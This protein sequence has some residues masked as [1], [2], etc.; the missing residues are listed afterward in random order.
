RNRSAHD[1]V[2]EHEAFTLLRRLDVDHHV[3]V[4][5]FTARLANEFPFDFLDALLDRLA[6][7]NLRTPDIRIDLE[8]ALHAVDDDLEVQFAHSGDDRLTGLLIGMNAERRI[9]FRQLL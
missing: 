4:L 2:L 9:L 6:I 8:L 3:P 7:S 1:L 5:T